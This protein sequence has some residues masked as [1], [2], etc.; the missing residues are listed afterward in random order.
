MNHKPWR[1]QNGKIMSDE[2]LRTISKRW[3]E[4]TWN[5][6]LADTLHDS[7]EELEDRDEFYFKKDPEYSL[8]YEAINKLSL[9]QRKLV[10]LIFWQGLSLKQA[11][12]VLR[13]SKGTCQDLKRRSLKK[14]KKLM[15]YPPYDL[16][17][18]E[19]RSSQSTVEYESRKLSREAEILE[20]YELDKKGL[21]NF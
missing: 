17:S 8:L 6:F 4:E 3:D 13:I 20:V 9:R 1:D 10:H 14:L 2:I 12:S 16:S 5:L 18:I 15:G 7:E 11:S 19:G 21:S